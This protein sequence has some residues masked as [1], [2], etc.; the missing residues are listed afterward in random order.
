[1]NILKDLLKSGKTVVGTSVT[2]EVDVTTLANSGYDFLLFD[3]QHSPFE[4]KQL[5]PSVQSMRGAKAAPIIRVS[6]N[7]EDLICMALDAGARGLIAP[8]VNT[9]EQAENLVR[10]CKYYP[11]GTRSNSGVRGD[12]GEDVSNISR[13]EMTSQ[14]YRNYLDIVNK[15]L[16]IIP[17]IETN[18]AIDNIEGILSVSGIDVL[19]IGPSDLSIELG[20]AIDYRS[21]TYQKSLDKIVASCNNHDV[22]PGMYFIPPGMDPNFYVD[23]GFKFFTMPWTGWA[24]E[25]IRSGLSTIKR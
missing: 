5:L 23:K 19:L 14:D 10:A 25:G 22:V 12:W 1:M 16:V 2:P 24:T 9:K 18:E 11:L 4:V 21:D 17:M 8:M 13:D 7:R 20:V 3:T 15:E 6:Q